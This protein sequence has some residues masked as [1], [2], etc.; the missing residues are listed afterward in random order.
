MPTKQTI[1]GGLEDI[2]RHNSGT[3]AR[4]SRRL[5]S[6]VDGV[7]RCTKL[8][9]LMFHSLLSRCPSSGG[10][11]SGI[12]SDWY[13]P[14]Q[15]KLCGFPKWSCFMPLITPG[16]IPTKSTS[17]PG[18][19]TKLRYCRKLTTKQ[20]HQPFLHFAPRVREALSNGEPVVALESTIIS[21]GMPYPQ[22]IQTARQVEQVVAAHGSTPATIALIDGK[23]HIGLSDSELLRLGEGKEPVVKTSRRDMAMVLSQGIL[24]ATTVSGTML[25]AHMAGIQVFATGGIGGVHRGAE[26]TMDISADLTE[27]GRTPVAVVCA[28]AKSI[29]DLPKTLEYLETLGVPVVAYGDSNDFPAFFIPKSGLKAP[30]S[31]NQPDQVA[32]LISS[33]MSLGLQNGLVIAVPIPSEHVNASSK[34]EQAIE[35]ALRELR[36][37]GIYGKEATPFLLKRVA[38]ITGGA[39]LAANIE[40]VKN[41]AQ[42][43]SQ[44]AR[45]LA[46][47][48]SSCKIEKQTRTSRPL[49]V[50]GCVA[51]D[52]ISQIQANGSSQLEMGTSYPGTASTSIGGV[53][54]NIACA[55]HL[56]GADTALLA[57]LGNDVYG[58]SIKADMQSL[59]MDTQFLQYPKGNAHT[60]MCKMIYEPKGEL[61]IAVADMQINSMLNSQHIDDTFDKLNPSVVGL[62]ANI[63]T[64]AIA[65]VLKAAKRFNSCVVFE[66]TSMP[67]STKVLTAL[68]MIKQEKPDTDVGNLV[69]ILTPN[70]LELKKLAQLALELGLVSGKSESKAAK[71]SATLNRGIVESILTLHSLFPVIIVKL[72]KE[73][74]AVISPSTE[75]TVEIRHI[76]PHK[77]RMVKNTNGAGDSMVGAL[78]AQF[79][80]HQYLLTAN[81]HLTLAPRDVDTMVDR[82]QRA[83]IKSIESSHAVSKHLSSELLYNI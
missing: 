63:E 24:G 54:H 25:A 44:I 34:I 56:L 19:R 40:L 42:I 39:S 64:Q 83:A 65:A 53:G 50:V 31:L 30:W 17:K 66:P 16:L 38:E 72:G 76:Q 80:K 18:R 61:L 29:L 41:N 71:Y 78:L 22:N 1:L 48:N 9:M 6:L 10:T 37:Y 57:T 73:G 2:L 35:V 4:I 62:D 55:A 59:G 21:H 51:M 67:K 70:V 58:K 8:T 81:G 11:G 68:I 74:A 5:K 7:V 23:I 28:G 12:S 26:S 79:Y 43:A 52:I 3:A 20:Y 49:L 27:L 75:N 82:A 13:N 60:A 15:K 45:S 36:D 47:I 32:K 46:D 33:S 14:F 77:P 69:H